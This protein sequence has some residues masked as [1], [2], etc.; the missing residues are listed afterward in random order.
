MVEFTRARLVINRST[1]LPRELWFEEPNGNE[2][3]WDFPRMQVNANFS[4][5]EFATPA[6][7]SGWRM[8]TVPPQP[9][10][11]VVRPQQ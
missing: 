2:S 7:P 9:Q 5:T 11:R 3:K 6:V 1:Y 10:P 4:A 8:V